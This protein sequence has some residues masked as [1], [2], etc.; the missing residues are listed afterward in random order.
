MIKQLFL[1]LANNWL[2]T[3]LF[4]NILFPSALNLFLI[5]SRIF[6]FVGMIASVVN[7]LYLYISISYIFDVLSAKTKSFFDFFKAWT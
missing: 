5:L 2:T 4:S 1:P 3:S 7:F 6:L